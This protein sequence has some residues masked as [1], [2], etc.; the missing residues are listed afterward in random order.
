MATQGRVHEGV[1]HVPVEIFGLY[2][3][4]VDIVWIFLFPLLYLVH[5][6][7]WLMDAHD[8]SRLGTRTR[9][10]PA[11]KPCT[12]A[13]SAS[14]MVLTVITV[15]AAFVDLGNLN[16]IV[17]LAI[18]VVKA[19]LVVLFFMHV[20]YSSK[21]TWVVVGAGVFWLVILLA[22]ADARLQQPR[23]DGG[24]A[25]RPRRVARR[26]GASPGGHRE[27]SPRR[28]GEHGERN[29]SVPRVP[30]AM[31]CREEVSALRRSPRPSPRLRANS[32]RLRGSF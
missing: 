8:R 26:R 18:A 30:L 7:H 10:H 16:V 6:H 24:S 4:F 27:F 14:L 28:R 23:L 5:R 20:K 32:P 3:H 9:S 12:S 29:L 2:W 22:H 19:T 17:A 13:S 1:V 11:A 21:L 25:H 31:Q 15:A